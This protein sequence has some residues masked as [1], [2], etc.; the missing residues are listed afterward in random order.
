MGLMRPLESAYMAARQRVADLV[1][2]DPARATGPVPACPAWRVHDVVAHLTGLCTDILTGNV[3]GAATD[4]WTQAQV[5]ARRDTSLTE[6]LDEW[7]DAGPQ[8]AAMVEDFPEPYGRQVVADLA[9]HEHD[10]RGALDRPGARDSDAVDVGLAFLCNVLVAPAAEERGLAPVEDVLIADDFELFRALTGRRSADQ[11]R[12]LRWRVDPEP[13]VPLFGS[14]PFTV[15]AT[16]LV[17]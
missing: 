11:I 6:V 14:G 15:R 13:Y 7:A 10:I 5:D 4:P 9:V 16:A 8:V 1:A 12:A 3:A 17:E 2:A